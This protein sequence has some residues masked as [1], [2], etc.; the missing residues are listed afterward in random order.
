MNKYISIN[1][2]FVWDRDRRGEGEREERGRGERED[3][4]ERERMGTNSS[5]RGERRDTLCVFGEQMNP[6]LLAFVSQ[7]P[8]KCIKATEKKVCEIGRAHV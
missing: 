6:V 2:F 4:R 7:S 5:K 3:R 8:E 1:I